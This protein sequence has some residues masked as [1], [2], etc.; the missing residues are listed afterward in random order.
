MKQILLERI[1]QNLSM[2]W[3][4]HIKS[5]TVVFFDC[6]ASVEYDF[7]YKKNEMFH[8]KQWKRSKNN[9]RITIKKT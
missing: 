8:N 3:L 2:Q 6:P 1:L 7:K 5:M 9:A 4:S